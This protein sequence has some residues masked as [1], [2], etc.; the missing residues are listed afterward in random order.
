[1]QDDSL[2]DQS[3]SST[4]SEATTPK[5][6]NAYM[7]KGE[8]SRTTLSSDA[9]CTSSSLSYGSTEVSA[10]MIHLSTIIINNCLLNNR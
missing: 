10:K 3:E 1:V 9:S 7:D 8:Q 2:M 5:P 6:Q 4:K